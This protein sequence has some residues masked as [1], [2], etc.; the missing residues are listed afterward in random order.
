[1]TTTEEK[2]TLY[3]IKFIYDLRFADGGVNINVRSFKSF[4][5]AIENA[6]AFHDKVFHND[7]TK[8]ELKNDRDRYSK[9]SPDDKNVIIQLR[10]INAD[11]QKD[12][13]KDILIKE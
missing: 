13:D 8:C 4:E 5:E 3:L 7:K 2:K 1:M 6:N 12:Y 11:V 10:E 9:C